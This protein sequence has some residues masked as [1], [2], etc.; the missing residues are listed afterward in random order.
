[1]AVDLL[2]FGPHP[3]DLEIGLGGTIAHHAARGLRVVALFGSTAPALGFAPAGE[4]HVV[5]CRN[6]PCQPCTLHGRAS[7]P[8]RHFRCMEGIGAG[9]VA[10][11]LT[12]LA[13][14]PARDE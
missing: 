9:E 5:L 1:M 12:P 6:E 2:V 3:D 7:C 14:G 10:A 4:G 8:R 13:G 11:A